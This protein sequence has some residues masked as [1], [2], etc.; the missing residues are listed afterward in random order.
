MDT[1]QIRALI[2]GYISASSEAKQRLGRCFAAELGLE[3]GPR[4]RDEGIDGSGYSN[5]GRQIYFQC[6]LS[7]KPLGQDQGDKFYSKIRDYAADV[8]IMLAGVGYKRTFEKR[9]EQYPEIQNTQ[10]H[11][12]TLQNIIERNSTFE[13]ALED[14]P[15]LSNL[16]DAI[17]S[18]EVED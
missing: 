15:N 2:V 9:K 6:K 14:L 4:G 3:P 10:I 18:G 5:D 12:L 7:G 17:E 1:T 8:G 13:K 11:L 16:C